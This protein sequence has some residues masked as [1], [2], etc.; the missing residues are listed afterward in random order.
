MNASIIHKLIEQGTRKLS[1][2]GRCKSLVRKPNTS[3]INQ[4]TNKIIA[5]SITQVTEARNSNRMEKL[6]FQKTLN[7]VREKRILVKQLTTD[8]HMQ[9]REYLK[10]DGPQINYQ[11]DVQHF[12]KNIKNKLIAAGK[13]FFCTALQKLT[14]SIINHFW[15]AYATSEENEQLFRDM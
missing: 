9:V 8:R 7:E 6:G 3:L 5:F 2:D 11:F 12:S 4:E 15:W 14:K 13:K 10:E 1:G